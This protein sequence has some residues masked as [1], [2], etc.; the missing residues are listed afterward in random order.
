MTKRQRFYAID[1]GLYLIS[2][3]L[4]FGFSDWRLVLGTALFWLAIGMMVVGENVEN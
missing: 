1:A 3:Y 2:V 4:I